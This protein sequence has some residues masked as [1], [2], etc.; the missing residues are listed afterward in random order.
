MNLFDELGQKVEYDKDKIPVLELF[1]IDS[2][3]FYCYCNLYKMNQVTRLFL[4]SH[5]ADLVFAYYNTPDSN[6]KM[7]KISNI[8][9]NFNNSYSQLISI[10]FSFQDILKFTYSEFYDICSVIDNIHHKKYFW[11]RINKKNS[12][13]LLVDSNEQIIYFKNEKNTCSFTHNFA[14]INIPLYLFEYVDKY[15]EISHRITHKKIIVIAGMECNNKSA[16]IAQQEKYEEWKKKREERQ[17]FVE[18]IKENQESKIYIIEENSKVFSIPNN[19]NS[20]KKVVPQVIKEQKHRINYTDFV[21]RCTIFKCA[22]KKHTIEDINAS[23]DIMNISANKIISM[24]IPAGYCSDCNKYFIMES[25]YQKIFSKGLPLCKIID[26][27]EK[28]KES[29]ISVS[30]KWGAQESILKQYGYSVSATDNLSDTKRQKILAVIIDIEALRKV[31]II[32]YLRYFIRIHQA[33][34]RFEK[35]ISKWNSDIDF[36]EEYN[37]GHYTTYKVSGLKKKW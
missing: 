24:I 34:P 15:I 36:T 18:E 13:K 4:I 29:F 27:R 6:K 26:E 10:G 14:H 23:I 30:N 35:A 19:E 11:R 16:Y 9:G 28:I 7:E 21:I 8:I 2:K 25:T 31:E 32:G 17:K 12:K 5:E 33:D 37:K 20:Y 3:C 1:I 22:F